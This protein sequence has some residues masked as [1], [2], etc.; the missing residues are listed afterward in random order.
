M[1][2]QPDPYMH[3]DFQF[4]W[5]KRFG[6]IGSIGELQ[7]VQNPRYV[8]GLRNPDQPAIDYGLLRWVRNLDEDPG[9]ASFYGIEEIR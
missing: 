3:E 2:F 7:G 4:E 6:N 1:L 8:F 5:R 9:G